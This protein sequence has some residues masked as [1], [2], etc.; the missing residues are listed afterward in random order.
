MITSLKGMVSRSGGRGAGRKPGWSN[1]LTLLTAIALL[2]AQGL[3]APAASAGPAPAPPQ[4]EPAPPLPAVPEVALPDGTINVAL[5]GVDKRPDR[6]FANT[7]VIIVASINPDVPSVVMLSIPRDT[8]VYIPGYDMAKVN[9]AFAL[10][11]PNLLKSTLL[12]NFGLRVDYY[13]MLNFEGV[14]NAVDALGG[15]EVV[16]TCP[17][18]HVFPRDPYYMGP[19]ILGRDYTDTFTGEVWKRGTRVPTLAIDIPKPGVYTLDGLQALAYIR[20]RKGIPGGDVDRGRREQRVVR[21][22][23]AKAK[24]I[25]VLPHIPALF[26]QYR[27]NVQTDMPLETILYFAS[28]ADKFNNAIIRSRFLD[29]GGANG[30]IGDSGPLA[31]PSTADRYN[32]LQRVLNVALNQRPNDGI[33]IEVW[34]GTADPGFGAAAAD[35]LAELG[36]RIADLRAADRVYDRT[37][38]HDYTTARKGSA[39]PLL[40]RTFDLPADSV[41]ADPQ[42]DGPRY[43]VIVGPDFNTCYYAPSAKAAGNDAIGPESPEQANIPAPPAVIAEAPLTPTETILPAASLPTEVAVQPGVVIN[44]RSGPSTEYRVI[45]SLG[46]GVFAPVLGKSLDD[47]WWH[48]RYYG[49]LGWVSAEYAQPVGAPEDVVAEAG[50]ITVPEVSVGRGDLVNVRSGPGTGYDILGRL[51][52]GQRAGIIGKSDNDEWWQIR[53]GGQPAWVSARYVRAIGD[54]RTVPTVQ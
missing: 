12:Y 45:G 5:L 1:L 37:V 36:F 34:N 26:E 3:N 42:K 21:A 35:R 8:L 23:F 25:N 15:V 17:L 7:D 47:Q 38:I 44:V 46:A 32:Y 43:R 50:A 24:Q 22:L 9:T 16:S 40:L 11:G 52:G 31:L 51:S 28:I 48:I 13:A 19:S 18:Y 49:K 54:V 10:G 20:A 29:Y 14:V 27:Q 41:I 30:L 53:Y 4:Q 6:N 33:P 39:V 2:I